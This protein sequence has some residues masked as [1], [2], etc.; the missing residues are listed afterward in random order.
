MSAFFSADHRPPLN[1]SGHV[2]TLAKVTWGTTS[3]QKSGSDI[4]SIFF[5]CC[6][7]PVNS[8][9][10]SCQPLWDCIIKFASLSQPWLTLYIPTKECLH[11]LLLWYP[12]K[13][14]FPWFCIFFLHMTTKDRVKNKGFS[15][16]KSGSCVIFSYGHTKRYY[17][18]MRIR[19]EM[20]RSTPMD[21]QWYQ[22][23]T[24]ELIRFG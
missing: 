14:Q 5:T 1:S 8:H 24:W 21:W 20:V 19:E 17:C 18:I 10:I 22:E 2:P 6:Q 9:Y 16:V 15:N 7:S 11:W 13:L 4:A 23:D 12:T 3:S